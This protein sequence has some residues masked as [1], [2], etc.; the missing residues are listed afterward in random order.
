MNEVLTNKSSMEWVLVDVL[1]IV[2]SIIGNLNSM[3]VLLAFVEMVTASSDFLFFLIPCK[4]KVSL[5]VLKP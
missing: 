5:I 3:L 2:I 1:G 4:E